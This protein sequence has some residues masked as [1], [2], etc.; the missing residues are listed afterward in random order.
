[1]DAEVENIALL[2][3][4]IMD[5]LTHHV[6]ILLPDVLELVQQ[7]A[8]RMLAQVEPHIQQ[9]VHQAAQMFP[10]DII[11]LDVLVLVDVRVKHNVNLDTCAA[12]GLD[13]YVVQVDM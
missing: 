4:A 9:A 5:Q 7:L 1:M 6:Q 13:I 11:Q 10:Q 12:P 8:V 2:T 3:I